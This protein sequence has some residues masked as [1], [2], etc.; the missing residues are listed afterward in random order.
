MLRSRAADVAACLAGADPG[1]HRQLWQMRAPAF[2]TPIRAL[3][4]VLAAAILSVSVAACGGASPTAAV[5]M[6]DTFN[7]GEQ[8][9]SGVLDLQFSLSGSG[10]PA[11]GKP[12]QVHLSGPF[13]SAGAHRLPEFA[14][15]MHMLAGGHSLQ[16]GATS[17]KG[18]FFLAVEGTQFAL[19]Q[20]DAE[21]LQSGYA[22]AT[23]H[24]GQG[25][26]SF[27]TL[28]IEPGGWLTKPID[29]GEAS[30]DG[31]A[32]QHI[33]ANLDA[34][35]FLSAVSRLSQAAGSL[36]SS[37]LSGV[38]SPKLIDALARSI[39]GAQVDVYTGKADHL[40]RRLRLR[41]SLS[42]TPEARAALP[43]L[44]SAK[45]ALQITL[46]QVNRHQTI[47]V[48]A[49]AKPLSELLSSLSSLGLVQ[50]SASSSAEEAAGSGSAGASPGASGASSAASAY[51]KCLQ[52][53]GGSVRKMQHCAALL[54]AR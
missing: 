36:G 21:A 52:A 43:G 15:Q 37:Q 28:G 5:L 53:A 2:N 50:S 9:E 45:L 38:L 27:A 14:L 42:L 33:R 40:L 32:T 26:S 20:Q 19:P 22:Q 12:V 13:E 31:E 8:I 41:A 1:V 44:S 30:I 3:V 39:K 49:H 29:E 16:L 18:R 46:S 24:A 35:K 23:R 17:A 6:R 4:A 7:G 54:S 51:L 10:S 11:L 48:P 25:A 34:H 47:T